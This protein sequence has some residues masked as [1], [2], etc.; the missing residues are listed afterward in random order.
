MT[1]CGVQE[2]F[3]PMSQSEGGNGGKTLDLTLD[4]L[5]SPPGPQTLKRKA[6][7]QSGRR[8]L[9]VWS[10]RLLLPAAAHL[11]LQAALLIVMIFWVGLT[12][13]CLARSPTKVNE[14]LRELHLEAQGADAH[15][16][17]AAHQHAAILTA[18]LA[19]IF[20]QALKSLLLRPSW[21][22]S[23]SFAVKKMCACH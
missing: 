4:A 3:L 17:D 12:R 5:K 1:R 8:N 16:D 6:P 13:W 10:H 2:H 20:G 14:C 23:S 18:P 11:L 7:D 19:Q 9:W 15:G 22:C 21:P